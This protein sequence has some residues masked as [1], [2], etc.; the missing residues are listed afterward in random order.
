MRGDGNADGAV[1]IG[2]PIACLDYLFASGEEPGCGDAA[3]ANDDGTIDIADAVATLSYLFGGGAPPPD[4]FDDCGADSTDDGLD[5][6]R[7]IP[8]E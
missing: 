6:A 3:D 7:F 5:C 2:D 8:C 1:D 4:P